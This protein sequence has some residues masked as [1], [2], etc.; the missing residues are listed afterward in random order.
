MKNKRIGFLLFFIFAMYSVLCTPYC[1]SAAGTT[2]V[3]FLKVGL[4]ARAV[5]MGEAFTGIADDVNAI[6]WNPSGIAQLQ[7]KQVSFMYNL[8][9]LNPS[10][11]DMGFTYLAYAQPLVVKGEDWGAVGGNFVYAN[12]GNFIG[13]DADAA[14]TAD[15]TC[16][17]LLITLCYAKNLTISNIP[18]AFGGNLKIIREALADKDA[19]GVAVDLGVFCRPEEMPRLTIGASVQNIGTSLVFISDPTPIP[20]LVK[21]GAGYDLFLNS[22][23]SILL[24]ADLVMASDSTTG[25]HIGMEYAYNAM[26]FARLGYKTDAAANIDVLAGLTTGVGMKWDRYN[27]DFAFVPSGDLGNSFRLSFGAGL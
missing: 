17:D 24:G 14:K 27:V 19:M 23:N 25:L 8:Y 22:S 12:Y 7:G 6:A 2:G 10:F 13:Y 3:S 26:F 21:I 15:F 18:V 9:L 1:L 4:G 20:V 11:S 5:G 16:S